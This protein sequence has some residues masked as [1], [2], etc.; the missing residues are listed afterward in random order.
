[1][2]KRQGHPFSIVLPL[3]ALALTAVLLLQ[4]R[5]DRLASQASDPGAAEILVEHGG[6]LTLHVT[7]DAGSRSRG[8]VEL[9]V[10][11][12]GAIIS[13]PSGWERREVRGAALNA[14]TADFS[15]FGVTRWRLPAGITL[16]LWTPGGVRMGIRNAGPVP[17]LVLGK[18]VDIEGGRVEEKSVL[19]QEGVSPL[20]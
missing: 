13:V 6:A 20:W 19:V 3:C 1:M 12:S 11:G 17:V 18:K 10:E 4:A 16:S 15:G 7:M 14:V 8:I 5:S 9:R 2:S